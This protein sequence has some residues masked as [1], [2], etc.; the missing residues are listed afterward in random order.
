M[1]GKS[2][3]E[4]KTALGAEVSYGEIKLV[5]AHLK[6]LASNKPL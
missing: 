1:R 6:H 5:Q 3:G 4:I 2:L